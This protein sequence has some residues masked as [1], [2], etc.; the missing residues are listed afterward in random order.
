[1]VVLTFGC[2]SSNWEAELNA[3]LQ[4]ESQ[5][6]ESFR[7][8]ELSEAE[9]SNLVSEVT[10][11]ALKIINKHKKELFQSHLD[12]LQETEISSDISD[13]ISDISPSN[14]QSVEPFWNNRHSGDELIRMSPEGMTHMV[15]ARQLT[16]DEY[17]SV[18]ANS[19]SVHFL[20]LSSTDCKT[21]MLSSNTIYTVSFKKE[22][23]CWTPTELHNYKRK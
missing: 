20:S 10:Q 12:A 14:K 9:Y 17:T 21:A 3:L 11:P 4:K 16:H 5:L 22:H 6:H 18:F 2:D 19:Q 13:L 1:M 8:G 15:L 23:Y 7:N